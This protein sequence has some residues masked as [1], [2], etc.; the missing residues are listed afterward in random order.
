MFLRFEN[1]SWK[2]GLEGFGD[3]GKKKKDKNISN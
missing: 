2:F 1:F 3:E